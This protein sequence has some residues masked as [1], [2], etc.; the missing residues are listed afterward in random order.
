VNAPDSDN[1]QSASSHDS[2]TCTRTWR[3]GVVA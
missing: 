3:N 2:S 1:L